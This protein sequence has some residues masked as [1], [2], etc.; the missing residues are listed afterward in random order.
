M[1]KQTLDLR[2]AAALTL[3]L[4]LVAC[5]DNSNSSTDVADTQSRGT[6]DTTAPAPTPPPG[7]AGQINLIVD[8]EL[9]TATWA[10]GAGC[11]ACNVNN[12]EGVLDPNPENF[13]T[14][15]VNLATLGAGI[16]S[17][18][19]LSV[20]F[21]RTV[22]PSVEVPLDANDPESAVLPANM[23]GFVVS[24]PDVQVAS[25]SVSPLITIEALAGEEVVAE[26]TYAFGLGDS[27]AVG[28][29]F[30]D[31]NNAAVYLGTEANAPYDS[32]RISMSGVLADALI[33]LDV[34][35]A[36]LHGFSGSV[37]GDF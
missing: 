31:I 32:I 4:L 22:Y 6:A 33:N 18:L 16:D 17:S 24:F 26:T 1:K 29:V 5:G 37:S 15:T 14:M 35:Q 8:S 9:A 21:A 10:A 7:N 3:G 27:L 20:N 19:G 23:P 13:A 11:L 36:G 2:P 30:V 34:L 25:A 28:L 12:P